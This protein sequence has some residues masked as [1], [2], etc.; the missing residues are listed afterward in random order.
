MKNLI[1]IIFFSANLIGFNDGHHCGA[2]DSNLEQM[3]EEY[4]VS[5]WYFYVVFVNGSV[6]SPILIRNTPGIWKRGGKRLG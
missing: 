1:L 3:W 6:F 5:S 4:K 2:D